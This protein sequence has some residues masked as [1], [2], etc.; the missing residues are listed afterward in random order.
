[1]NEPML[2]TGPGIRYWL[3]DDVFYGDVGDGVVLLDLRRNRYLGLP[4]MQTAMLSGLVAD[5]PVR[6]PIDA[7]ADYD[8]RR[9][10]L[11]RD[12]VNSGL[13]SAIQRRSNSVELPPPAHCN[14]RSIDLREARTPIPARAYA[15]FAAAFLR[16][17]LIFSSCTLRGVIAHLRRQQAKSAALQEP[18]RRRL[19]ELL[20][21]FVILRAF[22][23]TSR[24]R[25]VLDSLVLAEFLRLHGVRTTFVIGVAT[26]PFEAHCWLQV[27]STLVHDEVETISNYVP[28][29]SV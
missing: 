9:H 13:L 17:R 24:D 2:A 18:T 8:A 12:L 6:N 11:A 29:L 20:G 19:A 22:A 1:M 16:G 26:R 25:C 4:E 5:W 7:S 27:G 15:R 21:H 14:L 10:R 23:Y 28:L 3:K